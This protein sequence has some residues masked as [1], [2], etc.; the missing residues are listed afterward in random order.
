MLAPDV[1]QA[2]ANDGE[3]GGMTPPFVVRRPGPDQISKL[4][5]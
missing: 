2:K 3:I 4:T 5:G 1:V